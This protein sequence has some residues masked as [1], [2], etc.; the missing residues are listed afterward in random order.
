MKLL[1]LGDLVVDDKFCLSDS[2]KSL[3][4]QHDHVI[5]NLE[6]PF[7]KN[8][9][10]MPKAGPSLRSH[11]S[12]PKKVFQWIDT[13]NLANN[14]ICDYS[15]SGLAQTT[16]LLRSHQVAYIGIGMRAQDCFQPL[17]FGRNIFVFSICEHEYGGATDSKPGTATTDY[18]Y[19]LIQQI[20]NFSQKGRVI[21]IYHGGSEVIQCPQ[22]YLKKRFEFYR[23]LGASIVIGHHPHAVQGSNDNCFFSLGNF[24]F[25]NSSFKAYKNT[26]FALAVSYNTET[27]EAVEYFTHF[28]GGRICMTNKFKEYQDLC[29]ILTDEEY[30]I[31]SDNITYQLYRNWY[32]NIELDKLAYVHYLRCDAHRY[33]LI[34]GNS[35]DAGIH[36]IPPLTRFKLVDTNSET[37]FYSKCN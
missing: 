28:S 12:N 26:D 32:K 14:H 37:P 29:S 15:I 34:M 36:S 25:N 22:I 18:E 31:L 9:E 1:F 7:A 2:I 13:V 17:T 23:E 5:A 11:S 19:I 27:N 21:V 16:S 3:F 20:R 10:P 6:A 35:I 8:A 24:Y 4:D 30:E 33:N